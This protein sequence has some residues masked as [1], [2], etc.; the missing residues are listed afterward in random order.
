[1]ARAAGS[2]ALAVALATGVA[3]EAGALDVER[4]REAARRGEV[5]AVAGHA[6]AERRAPG[7][8]DE[9]LAGVAVLLLPQDDA[10]R[11][12]LEALK[13][14]ARD[15]LRRYRSAAAEILR[16][17]DQT[18]DRLWRLGAP[19]LAAR[20]VSDAEGRFRLDG[21]PA[22]GWTLVAARS[23]FVARAT[24]GGGGSDRLHFLPQP[25]LAGYHAVTVWLQDLTV[26]T[27]GS[28]RVELTDRSPW[29]TGIIEDKEEAMAK[30]TQ[31]IVS[32]ESKPGVLAKLSRTLAGA[33]VNISGVCAGE[34]AG[35]G[36]IRLLVSDAAAAK[37]ALRAAKYRV[38]EEP[39][40]TLTLE[41]RPGAL[42]QVAEK[43][44]QAKINIR[45]AY[46]TTGGTGSATVVLSVSN[47][48]KAQ[49][50]LGG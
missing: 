45:C 13:G 9:P 4:Y 46:A 48:D 29:F 31:L 10:F 14:H 21:V 49:N 6:Y 38:S 1:M 16:A 34:T 42:A 11:A 19:D 5:G 32:L 23:V 22:G 30:I 7:A 50:V 40:L 47:A 36:K 12:R 17:R 35:R 41:N 28:E 33:G 39:A 24:P 15:S 37:E 43:L 2:L 44:A 8:P 26:S 20:T 27:G 18:E 25:R 3:A